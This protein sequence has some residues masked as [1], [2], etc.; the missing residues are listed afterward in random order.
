MAYILF[1]NVDNAPAAIVG[2]VGRREYEQCA[3]DLYFFIQVLLIQW[4]LAILYVHF[5]NFLY[6]LLTRVCI[7]LNWKLCRTNRL[8][9]KYSVVCTLDHLWIQIN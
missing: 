9:R 1:L 4:K 7:S 8:N 2:L 6:K 3:K 5:P